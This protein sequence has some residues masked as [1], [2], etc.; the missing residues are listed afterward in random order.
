[1]VTLVDYASP[2]EIAWCPGC[3]NFGILTA[4]KKALVETDISPQELLIVSGIGQA[5]K[6]PHYMKCHVLNGLHG[7]AIPAATGAKMANHRLKVLVIDGDGGAYGEGANH[8]LAAMRRNVDLTYLAHNNQVYG[9]TKGQASPTSELGFISKTTPL[10]AGQ[11]MN[12]LTVAVASDASFLARGFAGDTEE[13]TKLIKAGITHPGFAH[14][15]ILQPCVSF[16]HVNTYEWYKKRIYKAETNKNYNPV[17][18]IAAFALAEEWGEYI[19]TGII[20][21]QAR[22]VYEDGLPM[23]QKG[24]LV[25]ADLSPGQYEKLFDKYL[26]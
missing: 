8:W 11:P 7:R 20:Y 6:L 15:D 21:Q 5:P 12:P 10:G 24:P 25:S 1:M 22:P 17:D 19:P 14:I 2:V 16:N 3:G 18:K 9:L 13:L 26:V 4:L 23:L